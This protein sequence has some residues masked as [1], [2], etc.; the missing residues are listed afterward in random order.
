MNVLKQLSN[1]EFANYSALKTELSHLTFKDL[2]DYSNA[3]ARLILSQAEN[4]GISLHN[5]PALICFQ[6]QAMHLI[7][8]IAALK[9]KICHLPIQAGVAKAKTHELI[10]QANIKIIF[11][12]FS[13]D[14]NMPIFNMPLNTL[15]VELK[16]KLEEKNN[17]PLSPLV[18][19]SNIAIIIPGSG[20]TGNPKLIAIDFENL[21]K[22]ISRDLIARPIQ[23]GEH[24]LS[25]T[26][27]EFYTSK[28]R[29]L[30]CLQA[31][32][33]VV[34]REVFNSDLVPLIKNNTIEHISLASSHAKEIVQLDPDYSRKLFANTKTFFLGGSPISEALRKKIKD[35]VTKNLY[36]AYGTNEIGECCIA[37]PELQSAYP[38]CVGI[39]LSGVEAEIVNKNNEPQ[40]ESVKG[41][42]R[43]RSNAS[44]SY[45]IEPD[46]SK[47]KVQAKGSW[48]YPGDFATISD[49]G[50]VTF[51]GRSDDAITFHGTI[52]YPREIEQHMEAIQEVD[53][54][55]AFAIDVEDNQLP[56]IVFTASRALNVQNVSTYLESKLGWLSPK[57]INQIKE[58]P[59][60]DAGKILKRELKESVQIAIKN[61]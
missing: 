46:S 18:N 56:A 15:K 4:L 2:D 49:D 7:A 24:H 9:L 25:F 50:V 32:G 52:I 41:I 48:F 57:Y 31:G 38:N 61:Q 1:P 17:V 21:N 5:S 11:S 6:N 51:K 27:I 19:E 58:M 20:T 60:N 45:Y 30:A 33:C 54:V 39:F 55:A 28:R 35:N 13:I 34:L 40:G 59:R 29:N 16:E 37:S 53:D 22:L 3:C 14:Q 36:I 42:L 10:S 47:E 44:Y 43:I 8:S 23:A 12:D 26:P